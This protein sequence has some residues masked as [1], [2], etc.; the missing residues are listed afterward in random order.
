MAE[1]EAKAG[2]MISMQRTLREM[3]GEPAYRALVDALPA[4]TREI[5]RTPPLAM[6]WIPN[7]H[8][9]RV[10]ERALVGPFG[11]DLARVTELAKRSILGD[12]NTVYRVFIRLMSPEFVLKRAAK[13]YGQYTRNNGNFRVTASGPGFAELTI[14]ELASASPAVWAYNEGAIRAVLAATGLDSAQVIVV[15]GGGRAPRC[16]FRTTWKE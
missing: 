4:D 12:L 2:G 8:F 10:I 1:P 14:D 3:V 16:V 15:E 7:H 6:S 5:V 13:I 9:D 11:G